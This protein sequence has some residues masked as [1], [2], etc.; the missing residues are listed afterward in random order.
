MA[1]MLGCSQPTL[2]KAL[3]QL[4]EVGLLEEERQGLNK[5]NLMYL[6][7]PSIG[8]PWTEKIFQFRMKDSFN[9]DC[10]NLSP[11]NTDSNETEKIGVVDRNELCFSSVKELCHKL[12]VTE[13]EKD[14]LAIEIYG[15][16]KAEKCTLDDVHNAIRA[17]IETESEIKNLQAFLVYA[18]KN[19][20]KPPIK[21]KA[22]NLKKAEQ[23]DAKYRDIYIT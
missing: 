13:E 4:K 3:A 8:A 2:R 5:P 14:I 6:L 15:V 22:K 7:L 19:K 23:L 9:Q 10:N 16:A 20:I 11:I 1:Q 18:V 21:Q 17:A 12:E